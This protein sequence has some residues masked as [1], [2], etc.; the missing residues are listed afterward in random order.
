MGG[1][2]G[3]FFLRLVQLVFAIVVLALS[4]V[5]VRW[6]FRGGVPATNG[7]AAFAGGFACLAGLLGLLSVFVSALAGT[8]MSAL[9]IL[10]TVFLL[11]SGCVSPISAR[12]WLLRFAYSSRLMR[13]DLV[14]LTVVIRPLRGLGSMALSTAAAN[15]TTTTTSGIA[16]SGPTHNSPTDVALPRPTQRSCFSAF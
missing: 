4:I 16:P 13:L 8:I 11:A 15:L 12:R 14:V 7:F 5:A 2:I 1:K 10:A 6:Q 3:S 9:D